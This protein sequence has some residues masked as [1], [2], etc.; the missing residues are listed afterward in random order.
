MVIWILFLPTCWNHV[1]LYGKWNYVILQHLTYNLQLFASNYC[2]WWDSWLY[3]IV[4]RGYYYYW[5]MFLRSLIANM[6]KF[7]FF[8]H[9][10]LFFQILSPSAPLINSRTYGTPHSGSKLIASPEVSPIGSVQQNK[11]ITRQSFSERMMLMDNSPSF[12][13]SVSSLG[14]CECLRWYTA[15]SSFGTE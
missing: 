10:F 11:S 7:C 2:K 6:S 12:R 15:H 4:L 5:P 13:P 8:I 1:S 14:K 9:F 3:V